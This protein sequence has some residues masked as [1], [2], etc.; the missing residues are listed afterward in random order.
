MRPKKG[1]T[2]N[3]KMKDATRCLKHAEANKKEDRKV[4]WEG[5]VQKIVDTKADAKAK[6][7]K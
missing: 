2:A 5:Y 4:F 7:S 3:R 1:Y 6:K